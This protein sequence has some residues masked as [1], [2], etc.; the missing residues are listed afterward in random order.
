MGFRTPAMPL[1]LNVWRNNGVGGAYPAPDLSIP[2]GL[3]VG[4]RVSMPRTTAAG[5]VFSA[6][7]REIFTPL[8]SDIRGLWNGVGQD[9]LELP[10]GS[11]RFYQ[12]QD[13][14]DVGRGFLNEY[15]LVIAL[16]LTNGT[17][18]FGGFIAPVPLP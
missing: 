4:R 11:K 14:E 6:I 12:V 7:D 13:V 9:L 8:R 5:S 2:A 16:Y 1:I 10:A 3:S 17:L 18:S 15:R